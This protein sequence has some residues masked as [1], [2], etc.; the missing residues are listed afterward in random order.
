[1]LEVRGRIDSTVKIR[2]FKAGI[3]TVEA[4]IREMEGVETCAVGPVYET[5][6]NMLRQWER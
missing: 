5:E 3:P 2:G 4:S 1:M 6:A